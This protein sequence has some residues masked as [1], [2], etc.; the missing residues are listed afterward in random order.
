MWMSRVASG[1][2]VGLMRCRCVEEAVNT[3]HAMNCLCL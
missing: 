2:V 3:W 1:L